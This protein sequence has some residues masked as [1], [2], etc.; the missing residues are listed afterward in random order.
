MLI[1]VVVLAVVVAV[2]LVVRRRKPSTG[3]TPP[4]NE[5]VVERSDPPSVSQS[6]VRSPSIHPYIS[7]LLDRWTTAGVLSV[8]EAERIRA[9][10]TEAARSTSSVA[11]RRTRRVPA[12]A[13]ALGYLGGVLGVV[14]VIALISA[15][16]SDWSNGLRLGVTGGAVLILIGAGWAV[17]EEADPALARLRWFIW[18]GATPALGMFAYVLASDVFDW[19]RVSQQWLVIALGVGIL[20]GGLWSGRRRPFQEAVFFLSLMVA[21]GTAIGGPT[22]ARWAGVG[23]WLSAIVL[24]GVTLRL[25][26]VLPLIPAT[27]GAVSI[28]VGAYLTVSEWEGFG[29]LFAVISSSVLVLAGTAKVSP[30]RSP[31]DVLF[32]VVGVIGLVQSVPGTLVYFA[33]DAGVITG[34]ALWVLGI[35][36]FG[37][38]RARLVRIEVAFQVVGGIAVL[39]GPA[40]TGVQSLALATLFGLFVALVLIVLGIS[41][42]RVL[43]SMFGLAGLLVYV[44]WTIAHFFPGEGRAPLLITVSGLLI[45]IVA[46]V[47]AR[48]SG[49]IRTELQVPVNSH[50]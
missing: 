31:F 19:T 46:V 37:V 36:L 15:Y 44:P 6:T 43:L 5:H 18:A 3:S 28:V 41:P 14:G 24:V 4:E 2:V 33:S 34:L 9:F 39:V 29:F 49:R 10:E 35:V 1:G 22:D 23:M 40:I 50:E 45:V 26:P 30:V 11:P 7:S 38:A 20:N 42:G 17:H 27:I 16:W 8:A 25:G 13:E 21:V 48:L 32:G 47:L 12:I